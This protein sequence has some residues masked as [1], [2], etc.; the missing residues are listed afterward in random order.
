[1]ANQDS[2]ELEELITDAERGNAMSQRALHLKLAGALMNADRLGSV[3]ADIM[4]ELIRQHLALAQGVPADKATCTRAPDNSPPKTWRDK[5]IFAAVEY[6]I[7]AC[8]GRPLNS[9]YKEVADG[10]RVD[11]KAHEG[12]GTKPISPSTVKRIYTEMKKAK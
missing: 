3:P 6:Q 11:K 12:E 1:M 10:F 4:A 9:I 2:T 5:T 8:P 7:T